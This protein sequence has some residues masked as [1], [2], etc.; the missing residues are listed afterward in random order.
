[1]KVQELIEF[2]SDLFFEGAVQLLWADQNPRRADEAASTFVFHGPRYHGGGKEAR[3]DEAY[4]LTDTATLA[5]DLLGRLSDDT[6]PNSNPFSLAIAGYGSGKSHFALALTQ[7][8][9]DPRSELSGKILSN[10]ALAEPAMAATARQSIDRIEKPALVVALDGTGNFNL[11]NALGAS[12]YRSLKERQIDDR[13]LR[14]LSPRFE[15]AAMFV[16]RNYELR[17]A[18]FATRLGNQSTQN[19][20]DALEARDEDV[21][22][23]VDE[24]Y[25]Q[26]NGI[27]IPVEGRESV[28]DLI[29]TFC[30]AYCGADGP[31]SRLVIVFDEFGRF[32]EYVAERPALAGDSALQQIF[33]GI[34]DNASRAHFLGF[35]QYELKAYLARLG[36]RDAMHIQK[37]ITRFDVAQKYY[38]S[39]NLETI[40]AH[41]IEKKDEAALDRAFDQQRSSCQ[42]LHATMASMLPG[43]KQLPVWSDPAEFE[44]VIVRGCWPLHP[45]ATWFLTRQ[46]DIVQSRSAIT[47]VKTALDGALSR[48][49]LKRDQLVTIPASS[50]VAGNMLSEML[51][52]ER[53]HGGVAIDNLIAAL[54]KYDAQLSEL[55]RA[56]LVAVAATKKM[57]VVSDERAEYDRLLSEFS[58]CPMDDAR[59]RVARLELELGVL[60]WSHELKQYEIITDAAT[61]GQY[62]K[63]LRLKLAAI[64]AADAKEIFITR[65]KAW[66]EDLFQDISTPFGQERDIPTLEWVFAAQLANDKTISSA[67]QNAFRD[68]HLAIKPD[69]AK[70]QVI[71]CYVGPD[72]DWSALQGQVESLVA[73]ELKKS[74]LGAAPIWTIF[75]SDRSQR[76]QQYVSTLYV[77][78]ERFESNEKE[79]YGR[80]IPEERDAAKRGLRMVLKEALQDRVSMIG[81]VQIQA[82]RLSAEANAIFKQV[83]AN[84]LPFPFDGL[85]SRSGNGSADAAMLARALFG[86]EV[87]AAWLNVQQVKLQ[88]RV[89]NV[90]GASW[91]LLTQDGRVKA[92]ADNPQIRSVLEALERAHQDAPQR[93]LGDDLDKLLRPPYGCNLASAS[94]LLGLFLGKAVPPRAI[95]YQDEGMALRDWLQAAYGTNGKF[96]NEAVLRKTK[97][98][99]L[100]AD[101]VARWQV[102]MQE[103]EAE[104][105]LEGCVDRLYEAAEMRQRD[106]LPETLEPN[107]KYLRDAA[108]GAEQKL[109]VHLNALKDAERRLETALRHSNVGEFLGVAD[110]YL[111]RKNAMVNASHEWTSEQVEELDA[112]CEQ[113]KNLIQETAPKWISL[114]VCNSPQQVSDFRSRMEKWEKVLKTLGLADLALLTARQAKKNIVAVEERYR[115]ATSLNEAADLSRTPDPVA[116]ARVREINDQIEKAERLIKVLDEAVGTL[117]NPDDVHALIAALRQKQTA[118][119]QFRRGRQ[120]Q[121]STL[122]DIVPSTAQQA[123]DTLY[124]WNL[125]R[126]QF[127]STPDAAEIECRYASCAAVATLLSEFDAVSAAADQLAGALQAAYRASPYFFDDGAENDTDDEMQFDLQWINACFTAYA[128]ERESAQTNRSNMWTAA[129]LEEVSRWRANPVRL[130]AEGLPA[131]CASLPD[132]LTQQDRLRVAGEIEP[133]RQ[134]LAQALETQRAR[135]AAAWIAQLQATAGD[136]ATLSKQ[137]CVDV[138]AKLQNHPVYVSATELERFDEVRKLIERRLDELDISDLIA[139]VDAMSPSMRELLLQQLLVRYQAAA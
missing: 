21:Y 84:A 61:R 47:F 90:L 96:M 95:Q 34:Q 86:G 78:D 74:K 102:F 125:L 11:G 48:D 49:A 25:F 94:M 63:D 79:R 131:L 6:A 26:A 64:S 104:R 108:Q 22:A 59:A 67:I 99:F 56:L 135:D 100:A 35:I 70:G 111:A 52:A 55:D 4:R 87:S 132:F 20:V 120:E 71:Y 109:D 58:G 134:V 43:L 122:L 113:I 46:Q 31:F 110:R 13:V 16:R 114:Q 124:Q 28:Q 30:D 41:L 91:G 119:R 123:N 32:L 39:S 83:Y 72:A 8:L 19:I 82:G 127:S 115:Y 138:L 38:V 106:P 116:S 80:F 117:S 23:I 57:R 45:L 9:R 29:T 3:T 66:G 118:L 126:Q 68:W 14:E 133:L 18:E 24:V 139:R 65:A 137:K 54:S 53:A 10:L 98:I 93:T 62:Q 75:L 7:L 107:Y 73:A 60:A 105:T 128:I 5:A 33:Q 77:L 92:I 130:V 129:A 97:V 50:I 88:N 121:Y 27:H 42:A 89:R 37:Y 40:I 136:T 103:W 44:R 51:A 69:Q 17:T 1:M 36:N 81:G 112:L 76:I 12:I 85:S 15:D 2:R 101:A